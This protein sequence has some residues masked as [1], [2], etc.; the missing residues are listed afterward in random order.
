[1]TDRV[2]IGSLCE[3]AGFAAVLFAVGATAK[4]YASLP[5]QVAIHFNLRGEPNGWGP[6]ALVLVFPAVA[7]ATFLALT[8]INP[9]V[10]L[11]TI[12]LG[13]GAARNPIATTL[14]FAFVTVLMAAV[15]RGVIAFN[16]G[17]SRKMASPAVVIVLTFAALVV[18]LSLYFDAI[19]NP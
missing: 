12:V 10:G 19:V 13:P 4:S 5:E 15:S 2:L 7:L 14:I 9:V 16:L 6:R 3:V 18:A 17:H 1:M 8:L 11:D